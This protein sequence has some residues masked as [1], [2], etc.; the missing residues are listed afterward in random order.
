MLSKLYMLSQLEDIFGITNTWTAT[1]T[2]SDGLIVADNKVAAIGTTSD[3][4]LYLRTAVLN[5]NTALTGVLI[6][7]PV[8]PALAANSLIISNATA[9]GDILLAV[10]DGGHSQ[11]LIHL[12]G[13]SQTLNFPLG[14]TFGGLVTANAE[15]VNQAASGAAVNLYMYAD[16][17]ED[18]ADKWKWVVA[19]GGQMDWYSFTGGSWA[20]KMT[21][22]TTGTLTLINTTFLAGDDIALSFGAG[23]DSRI[24]YETADANAKAMIWALPHTSEDANNV[25]VLVLGD[26]DIVNVNLGFFNGITEP[27]LAMVN[28]ARDAYM[29]I[30]SG[31]LNGTDSWGQYYSPAADEDVNLLRIG[32][33]GGHGNVTIFYDVSASAFNFNKNVTVSALTASA[34]T[35]SGA[36]TTTSYMEFTEMSAPGAGAANKARIYALEGG[37]DALTDLCAVFQDGTVDV[38]AQEST[39]DDSPI[40]R[41]D[42]GTE[43]KSVLRKIGR[44]KVQFVAQFDDGT[45]FVMR[46]KR[47]SR[48]RW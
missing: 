28:S 37:G 45:E 41:Y 7:T 36:I 43:F 5:A 31:D 42:D 47:W 8:T 4:V 38:F 48:D 14:A 26:K 20:S 23:D 17:A 10:N 22:S 27:A 34:A 9:D 15:I 33:T 13:S 11:G 3:G 21:L 1:Q 19:D 30:G 12:D 2:F 46:E 44:D 24:L 18:N 40:F 16:A 25:P 32:F 6:G 29:R 39:P 35:F